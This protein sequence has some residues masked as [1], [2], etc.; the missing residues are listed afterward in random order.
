MLDDYELMTR[1]DECDGLGY[2]E[3][4]VCLTGGEM[5]TI[6]CVCKVC[7]GSGMIEQEQEINKDREADLDWDEQFY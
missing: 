6:T 5:T 7:N 2:Y 3:E 4:D 1:C